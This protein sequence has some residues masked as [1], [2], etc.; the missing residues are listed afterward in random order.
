MSI[1]VYS[2]SELP[3][4][5]RYAVEE[6]G[7]DLRAYKYVAVALYDHGLDMLENLFGNADIFTFDPDKNS[8]SHE[9]Y[10]LI[11]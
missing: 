11:S 3:N 9:H 5:D 2:V 7:Y 6:T 4:E 10:A 8:K 1:Q